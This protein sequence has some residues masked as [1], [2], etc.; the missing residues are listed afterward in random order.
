ML[1][2]L[3]QHT[4]HQ[5]HTVTAVYYQKVLQ[6]VFAHFKKKKKEKNAHKKREEILLH[7]DNARPHVAH[8]VTEFLQKQGI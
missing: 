6:K 8:T 7:H 4:V 1:E 3:Y 5:N 2:R